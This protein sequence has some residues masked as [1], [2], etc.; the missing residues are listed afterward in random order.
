M[1]KA[2]IEEELADILWGDEP[3]RTYFARGLVRSFEGSRV[4]VTVKGSDPIRVAKLA[5]YTPRVDDVVLV[6]MMPN[7]GIVIDKIG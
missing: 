1:S 2:F 6:L 3:K 4:D 7:G 5:G